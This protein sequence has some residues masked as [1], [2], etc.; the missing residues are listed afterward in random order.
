MKRITTSC[1]LALAL[2]ASCGVNFNGK[3]YGLGGTRAEAGPH[4]PDSYNDEGTERYP[5]APVDPWAAVDGD[6]P[7]RTAGGDD[8]LHMKVR[9]AAADCTA[10]H[11]H[12]LMRNAWFLESD[13]RRER[14]PIH[15]NAALYLFGPGPDGHFRPIAGNA[16]YA[17]D[18]SG[19]YTAYRTVP[20]TR[21]NLAKGAL[22]VGLEYPD[23]KLENGDDPWLA[24]WHLGVVDRVDWK[25]GKLYLI[26]REDPFWIA[27]SRV[28]VLSWKPGGKVEILRGKKRN[29][30]AVAA[31][32]VILPAKA[33]ASVNDPWSEVGP[34][35][36]PKA[37]TDD[38]P[39]ENT[40]SVKCDAAHDHC[41]RP[42]VWMVE[43]EGWGVPG[44][45]SGGKFRYATDPKEAIRQAGLAYRTVPA[46]IATVH[47]GGTVFVAPESMY[48]QHEREAMSDHWILAKVGEVAAEASLIKLEGKDAYVSLSRVRVPVVQW[49]PGEEAEAVP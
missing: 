35:K 28:A 40:T 20:A 32:D 5:A 25:T 9:E 23:T 18:L 1:A 27:W 13:G 31:A 12:C 16:G 8:D 3:T 44:R 10:A 36:Q 6:G 11:D 7:V 45:F 30:L 21:K 26:G 14:D 38:A 43:S 2:V 37:V 49:F 33:A 15:R 17:E 29:E 46:T 41:L 48:P 34:D 22:I 42:W 24:F 47:A 19:G 4:T 39:I